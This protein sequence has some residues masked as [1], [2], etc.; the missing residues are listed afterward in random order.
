[1]QLPNLRTALIGPALVFAFFI[2]APAAALP[3][4]WKFVDDD[5]A[6][7]EA[8]LLTQVRGVSRIAGVDIDPPI[9]RRPS[10]R[11]ADERL[12]PASPKG[13]G[14]TPPEPLSVPEPSA[15]ALAAIGAV[16]SLRRRAVRRR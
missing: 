13:P 7:G 2:A 4:T 9:P 1:M 10:V 12:R 14:E 8:P 6:A 11:G 5:R 16:V 15:L 3:I